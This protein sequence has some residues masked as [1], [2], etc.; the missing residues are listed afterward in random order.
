MLESNQFL[1]EYLP[2]YNKRS[3][4]GPRRKTI[5]TGPYLRGWIWMR[6]YAL[7]QSEH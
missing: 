1:E 7:R 5:S 6:S 2:L 3:L 4:F